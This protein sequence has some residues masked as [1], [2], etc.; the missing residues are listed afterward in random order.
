MGNVVDH[1][2]P[3]SKNKLIVNLLPAYDEFLVAYKERENMQ[4]I[5]NST[6]SINGQVAGTWKRTITKKGVSIK[7]KLFAKISKQ[8]NAALE[9][10]LDRYADFI[11]YIR[12]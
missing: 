1:T 3:A 8:A 12:L 4:I 5:F 7:T 2:P 6:I 10:Q 9:R 11:G